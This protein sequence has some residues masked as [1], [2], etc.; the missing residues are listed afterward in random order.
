MN[1]ENQIEYQADVETCMVCVKNVEHGG[2]FT[3]INHEG[4]MVNLCCP[5]CLETFRKEP[6]RYMKLFESKEYRLLR[7]EMKLP[8]PLF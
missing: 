3:R 7:K 6:N 5:L 4:K 1:I 8:P 2:F